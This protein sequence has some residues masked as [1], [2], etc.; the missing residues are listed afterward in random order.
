MCAYLL[1]KDGV[2]TIFATAA[3]EM[4][5]YR[6][7]CR[8]PLTPRHPLST[9]PHYTWTVSISNNNETFSNEEQMFVYDSKCLECNNT[10]DSCKQ[11]VNHPYS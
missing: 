4:P 1:Q 2:E 7:S 3:T 11:K 9:Q 6:L 8:L 5:Y 10:A